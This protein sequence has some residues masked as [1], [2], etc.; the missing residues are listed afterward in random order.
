VT[1]APS[2]SNA[3]VVYE[4]IE[5]LDILPIDPITGGTGTGG[6][7]Q[8]KVFHS[9]PFEYNDN[10]L[11][12]GQLARVPE[13][14][15][16]PVIDPGGFATPFDVPGD[17][18]WYEFR[19]QATG[20][21]S[22]KILF[23]TLATVPSGRP[24][25]PGAGNLD[26]D[27]YDADGNIIVS[28]VATP[29]LDGKEA[30]FAATNDPLF[31]QFNHIFVRVH[32][33][34]ANSIN[35]YDFDDLTGLGTG[36]P[37]V[38][39]VDVFGPRVT[40]VTINELTTDDYNLFGVKP[41][42]DVDGPTPL[43]HSIVVHFED[44]PERVAGFLYA[45]LDTGLT[46]DEAR[47]LFEVK[48]DANGI[49]AIESVIITNPFPAVEGEI[50]TATIELVFAQPLPDDRFTLTIDDSLRDP[51][52]NLLDGESNADEP[53]GAP[54]FPSGDGNSGG[55]FVARFT[56]DSRPEI[57]T[58]ALGSSFL[59]I[60]GNFVV[61]PHGTDRDATNRD[62]A[63]LFGFRDDKIFAGNFAS[64]AAGSASGFDKLGAY[65]QAGQGS[66]WRWRLDFDHDGVVDYD[67]ASGVNTQ[68]DP[69]AG[70]FSPGHPGD[71]IG[72]FN[73]GKWWLD[74]TGNNNI[75]DPGDM[76]LQGGNIKGQPIVGDFDGDGLDDLGAWDG[77]N[78][79]TQFDG[80]F[81]FDFAINGFTGNSEA[82]IQFDIAGTF[83]KAIAADMNGDGIDDIGLFVSRREAISPA[84][85]AEWYF[86]ISNASLQETG[87]VA[88]LN[89][90]F[91]PA[92][93]G[94]DLFAQ[95]GDE[96]ALPVVGNFDPPV[97]SA[98]IITDPDHNPRDPLDVDNDGVVAPAD[99]LA[100]INHLNAGVATQAEVTS[101]V[102][103]P[104]L[105]V[106]ADD[107]V[108]PRDALMVINYLNG[109]AG[110]LGDTISEPGAEGEANDTYFDNFGSDPNEDDA[111]WSLL[112]SASGNS[113]RRRR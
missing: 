86:L 87:T 52:G 64:A 51:P 42:N 88:A 11:V 112:A 74:T 67:V 36:N 47:G 82:T 100:I 2:T 105:D 107:F 16:S 49:V 62:I 95:F 55:D 78:A 6:D 99:V 8:I 93:F 84:E 102:T 38:E 57:G 50:P 65:G 106:D 97:S 109:T 48:G 92:P 70:D 4:G 44:L 89:H 103:G 111:L 113:S 18:D 90:P 35:V 73:A 108:A 12:A 41:G 98:A 77:G 85:A 83:Q 27:I 46:P 17:E 66:A 101:L 5:R 60:N 26:L 45:A 33:T 71:E 34:T 28:G 63:F 25:L 104:F 56:V 43:V 69:V 80:I 10:R 72:L 39:N 21:F 32:G 31:P 14:S 59:D 61:D 40:D 9:D 110:S 68:G 30:I 37:G 76:A 24:G 91:T 75:G 96:A 94:N 29:A 1:V 79:G 58:Y 53:N 19:P 20:T 23:D 3:D 7:G 81:R 54:F 13:S 22:V 15:T